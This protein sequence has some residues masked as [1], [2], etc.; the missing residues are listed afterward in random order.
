MINFVPDL[1]LVIRL[2]ATP[3]R[4]LA[5]MLETVR[6]SHA[7]W[8]ADVEAQTAESPFGACGDDIADVW[9]S[10]SPPR[11]RANPLATPQLVLASGESGG[12]DEARWLANAVRQRAQ[13]FEQVVAELVARRPEIA[14][15][16][17]LGAIE[18][19]SAREIGER[20]GAHASTILRIAS[21]CRLQNVHGVFGIASLVARGEPS[22]RI[23]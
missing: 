10:D 11:A 17:D 21:V 4:E 16:T 2:L 7:G 14:R 20:I 9:V 3:S 19:V 12:P 18:P 1:R 22:R 5:T 15:A 6:E 23:M 13:M 8:F